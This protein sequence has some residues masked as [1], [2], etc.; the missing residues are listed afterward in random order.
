MKFEAFWLSAFRR[1]T[2]LLSAEKVK[3]SP[4]ALEN[5]C[6][7]AY[8]KGFQDGVREGSKT[9]PSIFEQVFGKHF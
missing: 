3:L 1:N 5:L 7:E 2:K 4:K 9:E 8:S 6:K